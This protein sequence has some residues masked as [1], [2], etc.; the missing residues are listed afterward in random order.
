MQKAT[1][2]PRSTTVLSWQPTLHANPTRAH[3]GLSQRRSHREVSVSTRGSRHDTA[4]FDPCLS[5][6]PNR[7]G[8]YNIHGW[9]VGELNGTMGIV[10]KDF[11]QPAYIL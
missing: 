10:P 9:W 4:L 7:A 2:N 1:V 3:F 8:E 5:L 11:L 6:L